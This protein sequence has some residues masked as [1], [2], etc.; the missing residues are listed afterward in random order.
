MEPCGMFFGEFKW[1]LRP[2]RLRDLLEHR[3]MP[4]PTKRLSLSTMQR[5]DLS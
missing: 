3:V 2:L 4:V 5:N 1:P